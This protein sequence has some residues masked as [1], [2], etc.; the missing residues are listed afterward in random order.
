MLAKGKYMRFRGPSK[1]PRKSGSLAAPPQIHRKR[2]ALAFIPECKDGC[3]RDRFN[4]RL[5]SYPK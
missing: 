5:V 3:V 2:M 1:L 4:A